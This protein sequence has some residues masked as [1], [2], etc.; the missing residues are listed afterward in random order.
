M[1]IVKAN[2][3][4]ICRDPDPPGQGAVAEGADA[5]AAAESAAIEE[6]AVAAA[7]E[8]GAAAVPLRAAVRS[9]EDANFVQAQSLCQ[10]SGRRAL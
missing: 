7:T 10:C 5:E 8:A 1:T 3:F 9:L 4:G 6:A 2:L